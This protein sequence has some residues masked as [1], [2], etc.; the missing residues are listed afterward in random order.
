MVTLSCMIK[1]V[2][3]FFKFFFPKVY[4][5]SRNLFQYSK[6]SSNQSSNKTNYLQWRILHRERDEQHRND[7]IKQQP[8]KN[9][10]PYH[11]VCTQWDS[12]M[13]FIDNFQ[14]T[15]GDQSAT[16]MVKDSWDSYHIL[17]RDLIVAV[18]V[19]F[20]LFSLK[21]LES[22]KRLHLTAEPLKRKVQTEKNILS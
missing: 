20:M 1:V 17:W 9:F 11:L 21:T 2:N 7:H 10:D 16:A 3:Y 8:T 19:N 6:K 5:V 13:W 15:A 18:V 14:E 12:F 22:N 4:L